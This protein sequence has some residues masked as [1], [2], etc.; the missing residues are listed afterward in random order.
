MVCAALEGVVPWQLRESLV[1][2]VGTVYSNIHF[3][4]EK[5]GLRTLYYI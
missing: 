5:E 2:P 4:D 1:A 3:I